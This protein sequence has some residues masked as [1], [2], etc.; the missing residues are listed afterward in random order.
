MKTKVHKT[1]STIIGCIM[2]VCCLAAIMLSPIKFNA[3]AKSL[4]NQEPT[5]YLE[6]TLQEFGYSPAGEYLIDILYSENLM[7]NGYEYTFEIN[8]EPC[9]ALMVRELTHCYTKKTNNW[10]I[11]KAFH[12]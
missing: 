12:I 1:R 11:R 4:P 6:Q 7:P 10:A 2:A 9:Y 3:E 8:N 5:E